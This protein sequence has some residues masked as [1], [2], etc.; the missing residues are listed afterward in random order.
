MR[1]LIAIAACVFT[2]TAFGQKAPELGYVFPPAVTAG[3][4]TKVK[5]G[6]YDFT[7]D[8]QFFVHDPAVTLKVTGP[9][10]K[11]FVPPPPYWFGERGSTT[12]VPIPREV[13][14]EISVP[15]TESPGFVHWQVANA[16]GSSQTAVFLVT[17]RPE[18]VEQRYRD[19][20]QD[21]KELPVGVSGRLS[22]L[23]EI[24]RYRITAET[25]GPI[26]VELFTRRLGA[27]LF[28]MLEL[29]D[30]KGNLIAEAADTEGLD[31]A[32]TFAAKKQQ[33]YVLSLHDSDF[34]G[35]RSRIY[36][37]AI[38]QGPR[39]VATRPAFGKRGTT[40]DV[41][42]IGYGVATGKAVLET[43]KR[44]VAFPATP[45]QDS[46]R[47]RLET[48]HGN[49]PA[50]TIPM[51]SLPETVAEH[52]DTPVPFTVP[53]AV[54][55]TVGKSAAR[56]FRLNL[57]KGDTWNLQAQS[58]EIGTRLDL[59][60]SM[61][62]ADGTQLKQNDDL[63]NTVD[64]GLAFRVSAD[65]EYL[66]RVTD[67]SGRPQSLASVFRLEAQ[68]SSPGFSLSVAQQVNVPIGGKASLAVTATRDAGFKEEIKL[69]CIGLPFGVTVPKDLKIPAGKPKATIALEAAADVAALAKVIEVK[70]TAIV[71]GKPV[72][73]IATATAAGNLC[74]NS[75]GDQSITQ[76]LL[77]TTMKPLF[78]IE[79]I[80]KNRQRAVHR[81]TTYPAP[82]LIKRD[83]GFQG[84]VN[85]QMI[86][87]QS[88]HRQGIHGPVLTVPAGV[89]DALYPVY[90]PEWLETDRTTRMVVLGVAEQKDPK[91]NVRHITKPADARIT[92]IL[93]GALLKV[94][95]TA[96][97]LTVVAGEPFEVP[98]E[99]SRSAKFREPVTLQLKPPKEL[100]AAVRMA[101]IT[102]APGT[103]NIVAK[104]T[105][106]KARELQGRWTLQIVANAMQD[107][108]WPVV[109]QTDVDVEFQSVP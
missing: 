109:S 64:A 57:K 75:P 88:R 52:S 80:D 7:P 93:E 48:P 62:K 63:P 49:S 54:T 9:P 65:G 20:S 12:A 35:H 95:H 84:P 34:R 14:A 25:D 37:L 85:L 92:M 39:V 51:S 91:G 29:R 101:P 99:L 76:V 72:T 11:F 41:E 86:A 97:D 46:L 15:K 16:N 36:R 70:G 44:K 22:K 17:D 10:G 56:E 8:M 2:T 67:V 102:I 23:T 50:I 4:P 107:N 59:A 18:I 21:I 68:R 74:P 6:G 43:V 33:T 30:E 1:T 26:T 108:K 94:S 5:L 40:E 28:G 24:D 55:A 3:Q 98:I 53:G 61:H 73:A 77:C 27:D 100:Q 81:G 47:Y 90:L 42:F 32:L 79:L 89:G 105:T 96:K 87:K 78:S 103:R 66:C 45:Q 60:I 106:T 83:E 13:P 82:F 19:E 71:D 104:I 58:R 31:T 69:E 38:T